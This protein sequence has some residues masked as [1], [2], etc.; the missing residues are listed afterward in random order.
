MRRRYL[1]VVTPLSG[2]PMGH[3]STDICV[4][5]NVN[6]RLQGMIEYDRSTLQ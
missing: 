4:R 2:N 3:I 1:S 5:V 6:E